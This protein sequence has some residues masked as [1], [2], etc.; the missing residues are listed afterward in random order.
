MIVV[1]EQQPK[2]EEEMKLTDLSMANSEAYEIE[3][4][5]KRLYLVPLVTGRKRMF[6]RERVTATVN[7]KY[8][9]LNIGRA[10]QDAMGMNRVWYSLSFD[11][12]NHVIA[13]RIKGE[14]NKSEMESKTW[15]FVKANKTGS[16][17]ISVGRILDTFQGLEKK[18]Y[19]NLEIMKY[20]DKSS[21]MD[22]ESYYY[23]EVKNV[24]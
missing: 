13:W 14:L 20:K 24:V 10:A 12:G 16:I 22:S 2:N 7:A 11:S 21:I 3:Q 5:K 19:R 1:M 9:M 17:Q 6:V 23:I 4:G 18:T 15:K 8:G